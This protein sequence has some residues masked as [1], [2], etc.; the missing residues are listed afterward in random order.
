MFFGILG[1]S[2][3][4]FG[5]DES[6]LIVGGVEA[7]VA[8]GDIICN[9]EVAGFVEAFPAGIFDEFF[10]LGCESYESALEIHLGAGGAE[11]VFCSGEGECHLVSGFFDFLLCKFGWGVVCDC[12]GKDGDV[13]F[14][15]E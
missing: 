15:D 3:F 2:F 9:D 10:G 13:D 7:D 14:G 12:R 4:V 11:D 6:D 8:S 1:E 5:V